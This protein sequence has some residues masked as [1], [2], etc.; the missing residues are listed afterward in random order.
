M[1]SE[2]EKDLGVAIRIRQCNV[3]KM[4]N[5]NIFIHFK[6]M[7]VLLYVNYKLFNNFT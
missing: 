2:I 4:T 1:K 7:G 6:I 5:F 3:K